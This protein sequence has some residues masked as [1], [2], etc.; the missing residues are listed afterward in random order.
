M[1]VTYHDPCYLGR[2]NGIYDEPRALLQAIPGIELVEMT[3]A[4]DNSLCCGGGGG[5]MWLEGFQWEHARA[6]LSEWRVREAVA[7]G[8][9]ALVVACPYETPRFEDAVK[10]VQR[11][12]RLTV[13]DISE[14]LS[15]SMGE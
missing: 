1:R 11:A 13:L 15:E 14:L 5:G 9:D 3:H 7:A 6:R 4:K 8:V 2:A 12:S 10:M